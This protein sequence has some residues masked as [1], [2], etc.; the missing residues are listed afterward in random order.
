VSLLA[1]GKVIWRNDDATTHTAT[2]DD[3]ADVTAGID[4]GN[5]APGDVDTLDFSGFTAPDTV[6]YHCGIHPGMVGAI[7]IAP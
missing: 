7:A 1:G 6:K 5:L 3:P 4:T 2:A